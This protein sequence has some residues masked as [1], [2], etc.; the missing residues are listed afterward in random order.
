MSLDIYLDRSLPLWWLTQEFG[1]L[2]DVSSR[3]RIV[4]VFKSQSTFPRTY[5]SNAH[6]IQSSVSRQPSSLTACGVRVQGHPLVLESKLAISGTKR[7][8]WISLDVAQ[9]K[10]PGG[11]HRRP[12]F[13][14]SSARCCKDMEGQR[15]QANASARSRQ[16]S[17]HILGTILINSGHRNMKPRRKLLEGS[18]EGLFRKNE[19]KIV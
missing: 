1:N 18:L 12:P 5:H 9:L 4:S 13:L 14:A 10:S 19:P 3:K 17:W 7:E 16:R 2:H 8:L 11:N 15:F 6:L